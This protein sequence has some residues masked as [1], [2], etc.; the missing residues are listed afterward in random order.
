MSAATAPEP[1]P[2]TWWP[3][4]RRFALL[5][6]LTAVLTAALAASVG[7]PDW[8][9]DLALLY[10]GVAAVALL[11]P[12]AI[13]VQVVVGLLVVASL[14]PGHSGIETLLLAPAIVGIV[15]TAE[16]LAA[17][18]RLDTPIEPRP[19]GDLGR[20]SV[21]AL[22]GG[23]VYAAVALA[24]GLPGPT[25]LLAVCLASAACALLAMLLGRA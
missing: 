7:G 20:A 24:A 21:A 2:T 9:R 1:N 3:A 25:G 16:L 11:S 14:L 13:T 6:M 8:H 22:M 4:R 19:R 5:A 10:V 12:A 23:G 18:A 15:A 17:V